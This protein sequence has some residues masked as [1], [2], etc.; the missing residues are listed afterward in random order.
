MQPIPVF[1]PGKFHGQRSLV[2]YS[3]CVCGKSFSHVRLLQQYGLQPTRLLCPW[4]FFRQEYWSGLPCLPPVNLPDPAIDTLQ[5]KRVTHDRVTEH[6]L[7]MKENTVTSQFQIPRLQEANR[8]KCYLHELYKCCTKFSAYE[9]QYC[10]W[11]LRK[12][13]DYHPIRKPQV[14][15]DL[16]PKCASVQSFFCSCQNIWCKNTAAK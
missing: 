5:E 16:I 7:L 12:K 2:G 13:G 3:P 6:A 14:L 10:L 8:I 11:H 1:L 15:N 4:R 9:Q